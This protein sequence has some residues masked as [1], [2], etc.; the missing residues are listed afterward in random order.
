MVTPLDTETTELLA[1]VPEALHYLRL[2][3][4]QI[5]CVFVKLGGFDELAKKA[6]SNDPQLSHPHI[7]SV[8]HTLI[9]LSANS[10]LLSRTLLS[11]QSGSV[12][13]GELEES[14][15]RVTQDLDLALDELDKA[16]R[17]ARECGY[18]LIPEP[19]LSTDPMANVS[20]KL[21]KLDP[22][23][24]PSYALCAHER[25]Q[26]SLDPVAASASGFIGCPS[27][28]RPLPLLNIFS[29]DPSIIQGSVG[30]GGSSEKENAR[31]SKREAVDMEHAEPVEEPRE[32][33]DDPEMEIAIAPLM[34][35]SDS[36]HL[37]NFRS[38]SLWPIYLFFGHLSK[39]IHSKP[40]SFAAHHLAYIPSL[41]DTIQ[42]VYRKIYGITA[43][44]DILR[45][46][47]RELM[48]QIWLLL[49]DPEFMH[50]YVHGIII[51]CGDGIKRRLF[52]RFFT[53]SADYP[54][55]ILL[56]CIKYLANCPCPRCLIQKAQIA[57][58][59]TK[60]DTQQRAK[61]REDD[62]W[63][64]K[65]INTTR[66]W[67]FER[68]YSLGSKRLKRAL[69]P[70]SYLLTQSAF[71]IRLSQFGFNFF[72]MFVPDLMHEFELG[73]W[74]AVFIHILRI[75]YTLGNDRIQVFNQRFRKVPTFGR[76][77]IRRFSSDVAAMK[78]LTARD[79]ED[80]LQCII[81]V[82]EGLLPPPHDEI[83]ADLLFILAFWHALAKLRLHTEFTLEHLKKA[84]R[85]LGASL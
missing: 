11:C 76:D 60:I 66:Q 8:S 25:F 47:K 61:I 38:A 14:F 62:N 63:L 72:R 35:W 45:F 48:Q 84:T 32:P 30:S 65:T 36:T 33:G 40:T 59:G 46:C 53:Y 57:A 41:L 15:R 2:L 80:I 31:P 69:D 19:F 78:K 55:K 3:N 39:Y 83:V 58:L 37:A 56:A 10:I 28:D 18:M 13:I 44:A 27:Y 34:L 43:T 85:D 82:M 50:A 75:L 49:L 54:E 42:D 70:K 71:S 51:L 26:T 4:N 9:R 81:P 73:V 16:E 1:A 68:G 24:Y 12:N 23:V 17:A 6:K 74:K 29:S 5:W 21:K 52:P 64:R 67:I 79:F 7:F 20:T 77:A 22:R